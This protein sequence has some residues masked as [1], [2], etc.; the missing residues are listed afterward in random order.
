MSHQPAAEIKRGGLAQYCVEH[1]GVTWVALIAVLIWGAVSFTKLGQQ[2]D[3]SIPQ[4][5][6]LLVTQFPGA[7][8]LKVEELVTKSLERTVSEMASIEEIK[9]ESRPG[10]STLQIKLRPGS[11]R[12]I[13]LEWEK[14]RSKAR[15]APLPEG[16]LPPFLASDFGTTITLLFGLTSPPASDAECIARANLVRAQLADLRAGKS[17]TKRAAVVA[18]FPSGVAQSYR[19]FI[20]RSFKTGLDASGMASDVQ[21]RQGYSFL[22]ADF[23]TSASREQMEKFIARFKAS[24]TGTEQENHPDF[25]APIILMGD[26]DPLAQVRA[27]A[28]PRYSYRALGDAAD[29]FEDDLKQAGSVGKVTRIGLVP[30]TV[31]LLY[32]SATVAGFGLDPN[33]VAK[34]IAERNAIIPSGTLRTGAQNFPVQL[35]GEFADE[36]DLLG[37]VV[38]VGRAGAPVYLR[39]LFDV[40]RM[41]EAPIPFKVDVF[42]RK[43]PTAPLLGQRAV[44][45]AVEMKPGEIIGHFNDEVQ[46]VAANLRQRLPDGMNI[47]TLSDQPGAVKHRLE[48]F[49]RSFIEAVV[50]VILVALLLMDWRSALVVAMAIPLTVAITLGGMHLCGIQLHQISIAALIIALGMLVDDPVV[51]SDAINR[52]LHH[53]T[54]PLRASWLGP[55]RMRRAILYGTVINIVAFLPLMLLPGDTGAFVFAIPAVVTMALIASRIVS[56]TFIPLLGYYLL[57]GQ[58]GLEEGGEVRRFF[59]F[60]WIDRG[61]QFV[62]PRYRGGLHAALRRPWLAIAFTYLVLIASFGLTKYFGTQFFPPAERNQML[63]DIELP[64]TAS[65]S[66]TRETA[67]AV[68]KVLQEQPQIVSTA[69][70]TGGTAPR[71]YYNVE[72]KAPANNLAQI[73]VNTRAQDDVPPLLVKL[74][75]ELDARIVGARCI[76]KQLEQ[77]PP[78]GPPIQ[79]RLSGGNLDTLRTLADQAAAAVRAAGGYH[80]HDDLGYRTPNLAIDIDQDRAN[81]L[82]ITNE[83]IGQISQSAFGGIRITDL[84]E[85]DHI[86]PVV[87]RLRAEER[88]EAEKIR[89]LYIHSATNE[90]VPFASFARIKLEPSYALIPHYDQLRTVTVQ[91]YAPAGELSSRIVASA[92]AALDAIKLPPGYR[93]EIAGEEKELKKGQDEMGSVM[94]VSLTLI[95]LAMILQFNSVAKAAVVL[96]TVPLGL[97]GA[98]V[99]LAVTHSPLGFMA[100]LGIVSLAGV[101]VSHIIVLSDFIEEARAEGMPLEQA[102]IQ[103]GLVRLRA[104]LVTV[105]ATVGGLLPLFYTGGALWHP[106]TAVHIFG[107]LLATVLTLLLLPVLYFVFCSRLNWIK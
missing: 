107:L 53:G 48:H 45:V 23:A 2:E 46:K 65:L 6:G 50:I 72:P 66:N 95:A 102:L 37:T 98:F 39:D 17:A 41:Y 7:T 36:N 51:A 97:I 4:R 44:M 18:F 89:A 10:L 22:M 58:K 78:I 86:I 67:Q 80:V 40:R 8:A 76:V 101:I 30:E 85:G 42:E 73:L 79:V 28:P 104:I 81:S 69:V 96:L 21:L 61:L 100:L 90:P 56:M 20:G 55:F 92:R 105:L 33:G 5:V 47:E 31:Y 38:G 64:A 13:D 16:A 83:Q 57:R 15:E 70:F 88:N 35:T 29:D 26:E 1:R 71:F 106:L 14:L 3:P 82:G 77:G 93:L 74:R 43:A 54:P 24:V 62:L 68:M 91:S 59:P 84:R 11:Q 25:T 87:V 94:L 27:T 49:I 99:G 12:D 9:S 32:S 75:A 52:E 60:S 34:A 103:G 63:V 19:S